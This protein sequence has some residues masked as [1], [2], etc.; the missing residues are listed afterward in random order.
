MHADAVV[1][2]DCRSKMATWCYKSLTL[3]VQPRNCLYCHNHLDRYMLTEQGATVW[4]DRK[5]FPAAM[6]CLYTAVKIHGRSHG[7][8]SSRL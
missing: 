3:Q 1:D 8:S 2:I 5:V 7:R 6:T 4:A